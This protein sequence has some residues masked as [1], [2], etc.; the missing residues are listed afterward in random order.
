MIIM[1]EYISIKKDVQEAQLCHS[2]VCDS[3]VSQTWSQTDLLGI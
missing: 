3:H 1:K 2:W